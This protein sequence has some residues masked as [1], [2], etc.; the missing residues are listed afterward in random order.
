MKVH[1]FQAKEIFRSYGVATPREELCTSPQEVYSAA[2]KIATPVVIKAQVLVGGRGKAGGVKLAKTPAEAEKISSQILGMNIKGLTVEKVLLSEAVD[3]ES[4][5]YVGITNDRNSKSIV[6]MVSSAGGIDIE[7]IAKSTPEKI[8]KLYVN[9]GEGG[10]FDFQARNLAFKIFDDIK[11][12]RQ[13]S[14][15]IKNLYNCYIENDASLAEINPL[16][17]DKKGKVLALDAKI[18]FD[19][20]ALY[21][22]PDIEKMREIRHLADE[23][24]EMEAK[25][26]G[27]S[28][29]RL[30]GNIGC[31]VNGAGLAMATMD[32][33]KLYGG[34][35][36]NF[37]DIGGSSNPQKVIDAMNILL[38]DKNVQTVMINIFGGI[39]RCDDV[40]NGLLDAI[41]SL[42]L[43]IPIVIRLTGTNEEKA[44][45]I[46]H[47]A[48][49]IILANSMADAAKKAIG[50]AKQ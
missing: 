7:E 44:H 25:S 29:I 50:L 20:N 5:Y 33:I 36:A 12:V 10:L 13:V 24:K 6:C 40:A 37:L 17:L 23:A 41:H 18:N 31:M 32:L 48:K 26:K 4:E 49:N 9:P 22:H 34:E 47:Q 39:T 3:I 28:Y 8:Y 45:K 16:V 19:D 35:P 11:I 14:T 1:E 2:K 43:Q 21:R 27:L 15:I 30:Q 42:N 46:L 38:S